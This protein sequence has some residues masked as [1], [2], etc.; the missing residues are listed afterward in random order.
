[1]AAGLAGTVIIL[2]GQYKGHRSKQQNETEALQPILAAVRSFIVFHLAIVLH[3]QPLWW[4]LGLIYYGL[5]EMIL[6]KRPS[7]NQV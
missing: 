1:M 7:H 2:Y 3:F 4:L 5:F 6:Y